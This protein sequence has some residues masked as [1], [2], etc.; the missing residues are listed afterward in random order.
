VGWGEGAVVASGNDVARTLDLGGVEGQIKGT[1]KFLAK[2]S[3]CAG[4]Y[5]DCCS[6]TPDP[7]QSKNPDVTFVYPSYL[8]QYFYVCLPNPTTGLSD[9]EFYRCPFQVDD[10]GYHEG[11]FNA[12]DSVG[13][14]LAPVELQRQKRPRIQPAQ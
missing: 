6:L 5:N 2:L 12:D 9:P 7:D 11:L 13:C 3:P 4:P 1:G 10:E 14:Y 8:T